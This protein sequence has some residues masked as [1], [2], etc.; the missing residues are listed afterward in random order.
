MLLVENKKTQN[1]TGK[2]N[3]LYKKYPNSKDNNNNTTNSNVVN[4]G[5]IS[6]GLS[7]PNIDG[8]PPNMFLQN[9]ETRMKRY[10]ENK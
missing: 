10:Y 8:S 5:N 2:I 7:T 9:I 1:N 3:L 4:I 6:Y